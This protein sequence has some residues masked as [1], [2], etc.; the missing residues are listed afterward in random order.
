MHSYNKDIGSFGE[1]LARDYL[2]SKGYKILNMNFVETT[3]DNIFLNKVN[4][5]N[6]DMT[7]GFIYSDY[8]FLSQRE[9]FK[10]ESIN[11][12]NIKQSLNMLRRLMI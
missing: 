12:K 3:I 8:V 10:G 1:A 6:F 2:I 5:V 7:E 9:I 11:E 4:I